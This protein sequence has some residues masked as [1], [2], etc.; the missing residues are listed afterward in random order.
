MRITDF[1]LV[2]EVK[3]EYL[4]L[5][6]IG[7]C[8]NEATQEMQQ[9]Y[10]NELEHGSEDDALLFWVGLCDGQYS[11]K[12]I[13]LEVANKAKDAL[14]KIAANDWGITQGDIVRRIAHC[15]QAPQPEKKFG[16]PRT[17][18]RCSWEVGDTFAYKIP[19]Y[20]EGEQK[21]N[22]YILLRKVSEIEFG[23]GALYP[24]VTLSFWNR[25]QFPKSENEF[26]SV[27]LLRLNRNRFLLPKGF[28]E[29]RAALIISNSKKLTNMPLIYL[30]RFLD[31]PSPAD[32]GI[33]NDPG[34]MT[35]LLLD[36]IDRDLPLFINCSKF[37]AKEAM[38]EG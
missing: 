15:Q 7:K 27:P 2:Q 36:Y 19:E 9:R 13:T 26:N 28:Y 16:K 23:D 25:D 17:K 30:G 33:V 3:D 32:E 38:H 29:Y 6:K 14:Q 35:G 34:K 8:R 18:F 5:R 24:V 1:P 37:Y 31:A 12:E 20:T 22:S 11:V 10:R 4:K 21:N